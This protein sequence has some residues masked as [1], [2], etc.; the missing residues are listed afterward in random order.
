[1][2][3]YKLIVFLIFF[4]SLSFLLFS[5]NTKTAN[6]KKSDK[7]KFSKEKKS[8][9]TKSEDGKESEKKKNWKSSLFL[10][11]T[12]SKGNSA[13]AAYSGQAQFNYNI[14][15]FTFS[16]SYEQYYGKNKEIVNLNKGKAFFTFNRQ[17]KDGFNMSSSATYE[18]DRIAQLDYRFNYGIG[19]SYLKGEK[20]SKNFS[21]TTNVVYEIDNYSVPEKED[22]KNFRLQ[23]FAQ[24]NINFLQYSYF[25][26]SFLYTPNII[27]FS[28]DYR[29]EIK[30]SIKFLMTS[31][32]WFK[33]SMLNQFN[34][35]PPSD[36]I[37][38][39]DLTMVTG[40]EL[41]I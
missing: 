15:G 4:F 38:K 24:T 21:F 17:I 36:K 2:R 41:T 12:M 13:G 31:P 23:M 5:Q 9:E 29:I 33:F 1:M 39:N 3:K 7:E 11:Y 19:F 18:Y 40:I 10:S 28:K 8:E 30:T 6:V 22:R 16:G 25:Q 37:K 34:N 26:A 32:I 35:T 20:T 27:E 14:S